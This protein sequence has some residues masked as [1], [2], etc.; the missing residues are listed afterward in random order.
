MFFIVKCL[1]YQCKY[2]HICLCL[3]LSLLSGFV[4]ITSYLY[5]CWLFLLVTIHIIQVVNYKRLSNFYDMILCHGI[6]FFLIERKLNTAAVWHFFLT[7]WPNLRLESNIW[8]ICTHIILLDLH[9]VH[10][11]LNFVHGLFLDCHCLAFI[12]P[13]F[14]GLNDFITL[15][16]SAKLNGKERLIG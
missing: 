2:F 12:P 13:R 4:L 5:C 16:S 10:P 8:L 11:D 9:L 15:W 1:I 6:F 7:C 3:V 14:P